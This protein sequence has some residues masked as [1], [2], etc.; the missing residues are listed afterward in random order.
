MEQELLEKSKENQ[1]KNDTKSFKNHSK[2]IPN[3][4]NSTKTTPIEV[5]KICSKVDSILE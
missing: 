4:S 5:K 2:T 3:H 1:S